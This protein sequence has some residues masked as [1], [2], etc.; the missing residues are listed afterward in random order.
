MSREALDKYGAFILDIDG[1]LT[2]GGVA[3]SGS[4]EGVANLRK[5]GRV[6]LLTNNSSRSR[7]GVSEY[8]NAAGFEFQPEEIVTSSYIIS[9]YLLEAHGQVKVWTIGEAGLDEELEHA[10]HRVG[11]SSQ[12]DWLVTGICWDLR[13]GMLAEALQVLNDGGRYVATNTDGT[14]PMPGGPKPGAGAIVGAIS[15]M[16]Y[17]PEM[18]VGKPSSIAYDT[19]LEGLDGQ[20]GD[21][22]M[23][24]DR[25]ETDILGANR[26]GLDS[27]LVLTGISVPADIDRTGVR[28]TIVTDNLLS[29]SRG[30]LKVARSE[31]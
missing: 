22:L 17:P 14:F 8:L 18:V 11:Q 7:R 28:P 26:A 31:S 15:A 27:A 19:V 5:L 30:E 4:V 24:G 25:L 29:L 20:R 16:G 1:V 13:Y 23:V 2:R 6:S 10:G 21:V 3:I 12:A 9:R